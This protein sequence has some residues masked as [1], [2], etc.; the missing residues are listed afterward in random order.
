MGSR[1]E[2]PDVT[3]NGVKLRPLYPGGCKSCKGRKGRVQVLKEAVVSEQQTRQHA[4]HPP[5]WGT[6]Q[7]GA[8]G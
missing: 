7:L 6:P 5:Q 2:S 4:R 8:A 3:Y 1:D